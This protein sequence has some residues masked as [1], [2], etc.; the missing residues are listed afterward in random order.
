[1]KILYYIKYLFY[2]LLAFLLGAQNTYAKTELIY[3]IKSISFSIEKEQ[4]FK[5]LEKEEQ[6]NLGFL[7]EKR[8]FGLSEGVSA[9]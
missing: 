1:M 5:S 9:H 4:S 6:P 3:P 2:F 8:K 7:K